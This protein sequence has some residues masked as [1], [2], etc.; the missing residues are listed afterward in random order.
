MREP[1]LSQL[2]TEI[3]T[4]LFTALGTGKIWRQYAGK[5]DVPSHLEQPGLVKNACLHI[6]TLVQ[7]RL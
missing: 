7:V 1:G 3:A 6:M 5:N 4:N 2:S